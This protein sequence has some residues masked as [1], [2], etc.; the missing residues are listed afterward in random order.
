MIALISQRCISSLSV[1]TENQLKSLT[2]RTTKALY[3]NFHN[4]VMGINDPQTTDIINSITETH[5]IQLKVIEKEHEKEV[6]DLS[7]KYMD[8]I[9]SLSTKMEK[10]KE[11]IEFES[12]N[13]M[14]SLKNIHNDVLLQ[15]DVLIENYKKEIDSMNLKTQELSD[16][17]EKQKESE[18]IFY[19]N[20]IKEMK[21]KSE[22]E[23]DYF[24]QLLETNQKNLDNVREEFLKEKS[25]TNIAKGDIGENLVL[26]ALN[27]NPRYNDIAI[28]DTSGIKGYGDLFV[29]I[30][31]IDFKSI[32]EVK[33]ETQIQ[34]QKDIVQF[35]EH[36]NTFFKEFDSSHAIF[37]S[38]KCG[39]IPQIGSYSIVNKNG[40]FTGYFAN[41]DMNVDQI[42][43]N[44]YNFIDIILNN[45][46]LNNKNDNT[47]SLCETLSDNA[48]LC[49]DIVDDYQKKIK[50]HQEQVKICEDYINK[51][52]S[53]I[54]S[55]N[56]L[57]KQ[58]GFN[59][60]SNLVCKT[61][62]EKIIELK[63]HLIENEL[64]SINQS[65]V[66]F[67]SNWTKK[68]KENQLFKKDKILFKFNL[69]KSTSYDV[70]FDEL[71][72]II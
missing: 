66:E 16:I 69:P 2:E 26:K 49:S 21:I 23:I 52:N 41:D 39:R 42:K 24:K 1:L 57:L 45:R 29:N 28:E 25:L 58:E 43:H 35:D 48:N 18:T 68:I 34:T 4:I 59:V 44:F 60:S 63:K 51:L 15:K 7:N 50:F 55:S 70:I 54:K 72:K 13:R 31:S 62:E 22:S 19:Q 40:S 56:A 27:D 11:Q 12:N 5:D 30:P 9:H 14:E 53:S 64:F 65:K 32:I 37:F 46:N 67:K 6:L 8:E 38:L 10:M 20:Q 3:H 61:K 71:S 36:R 33:A 47:I 17:Y